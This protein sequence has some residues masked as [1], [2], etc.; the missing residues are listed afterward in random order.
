MNTS[1]HQKAA[2]RSP[3]APAI[4][5]PSR[6]SKRDLWH[7]SHLIL[8]V[9]VLT[10]VMASASDSAHLLQQ[11]HELT[12]LEESGLVASLAVICSEISSWGRVLAAWALVLLRR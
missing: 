10:G 2:R 6:R 3:R 9:I 8:A 11:V 7:L 1:S 4:G 5:R 12:P